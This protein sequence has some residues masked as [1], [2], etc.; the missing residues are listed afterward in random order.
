MCGM[1]ESAGVDEIKSQHWTTLVLI[2]IFAT[3]LRILGI[4]WPSFSGDELGSLEVAAGRGPVHLTLPRGVIFEPP[5]HSTDLRG[6]ASIWDVPSGMWADVHPPLYFL[7]LRLWEDCFGTGDSACRGLSALCG[8]LSVLLIFDV[9]RWLAG[10]ATGLWAAAIMAVAQPQ[11]IY[12]QDARPYALDV[13][14][15]LAAADALLRI[16]RKG[17]SLRR[18]IALGVAVSASC[19]THYFA[20]PDVAAMGLFAV[21]RLRGR[22][23]RRVILVLAIAAAGCLALWGR[24]GW[25][26]RANFTDPWM[27]WFYGQEPHHIRATIFRLAALP[28]RFLLEPQRDSL[29]CGLAAVLYALP[30]LRCRKN[31]DLLLPGF[32]LAS[33]AILLGALDFSRDTVQLDSIK[34]SLMAAPAVYLI[35]PT[36]TANAK[37]V[38]IAP[39]AAVLACVLAFPQTYQNPQTDF[40]R[41]AIDVAKDVRPDQTLVI[42]GGGWGPWFTGLLYLA[43]EHYSHPMPASVALLNVPP[44]PA[45]LDADLRRQGNHCWLLMSWT[46]QTPGQ[47]MPGW[48]AK[49]VAG[50]YGSFKLYLMTA[51]VRK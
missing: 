5:P 12:S 1:A 4:G 36:L 42:T 48:K 28:M 8:V 25:A 30:F 38:W 45:A 27:Y 49:L 24:Q 23:R 2:L 32:W 40:R 47:F 18:E 50:E 41:A 6:A 21:V 9:G 11:I 37:T 22:A 29:W 10:T 43:V 13:L 46:S 26:Q 16:V 44:Q 19:L 14:F 15:L 33:S 3:G 20:L 31:R 51:G 35:L 7:C 17:Q 34:Y 39:L